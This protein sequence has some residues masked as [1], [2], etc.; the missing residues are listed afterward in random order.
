MISDLI[1]NFDYAKVLLEIAT[2]LAIAI[3]IITIIYILRKIYSFMYATHSENV[4][5]EITPPAY[6]DMSVSANEALFSAIHSLGM[7]K[8]FLDKLL[9]RKSTFSNEISST[10]KTG[11]R[12]F[13]RT[14][15]DKSATIQQ[16]IASYLPDAKVQSCKCVAD[17]PTQENR[18]SYSR[19]PDG[20]RLPQFSNAIP[21]RHLSQSSSP[22]RLLFQSPIKLIAIPNIVN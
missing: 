6:T 7:N 1:N 2:W 5:L 11:I 19:S 8:T 13:M 16:L 14:P 20:A 9:G 4:L 18:H 17:K 15:I 21:S 22:P 12:F 3:S 10:N